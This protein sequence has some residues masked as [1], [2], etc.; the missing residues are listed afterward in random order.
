MCGCTARVSDSAQLCREHRACCHIW[1]RTACGAVPGAGIPG[2]LQPAR[3][4]RAPAA[5]PWVSTRSQEG[6]AKAGHG[7]GAAG[8]TVLVLS[9]ACTVQSQHPSL[10]L[11]MEKKLPWDDL[12][13]GKKRVILR[14]TFL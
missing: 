11:L 14:L 10:F 4:A 12:K 6:A 9:S 3:A 2:Q 8:Q 7:A 5:A 1:E 13:T